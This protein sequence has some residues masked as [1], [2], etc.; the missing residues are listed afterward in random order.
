MIVILVRQ[1]QIVQGADHKLDNINDTIERTEGMSLAQK[2]ARFF[3][4]A[5]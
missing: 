5:K 2:A 4:L 3:G 1:L